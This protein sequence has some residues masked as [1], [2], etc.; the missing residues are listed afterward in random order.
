MGHTYTNILLHVVFS[1]KDRAHVITDDLRPELLAYLG[2]AVRELG[3]TALLVNGPADHVHG[4]WRLP[5]DLAVAECVRKVKANSSGWVHRKFSPAFAW[6]TGYAAFSVSE[7][8]AEA[9]MTYIRNQLEHH[10]RHSF[11][12]ELR[13]LLKKQGIAIDERYAWG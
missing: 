1:T 9:V 6:Q 12:D 7:S 11:Q 8:R 13:A 4:L 5:A 2:G 10:R 3:G